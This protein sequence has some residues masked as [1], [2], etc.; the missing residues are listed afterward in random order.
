MLILYYQ[1]ITRKAIIPNSLKFAIILN[2]T[3]TR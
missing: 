2:L 3:I 1:K